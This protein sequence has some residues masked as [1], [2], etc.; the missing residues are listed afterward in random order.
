MTTTIDRVTTMMQ[1]L[2]LDQPSFAKIAG[3]TKSVVNQ[4]LTGK[5]KSI[6]PEYAYNIAKNTDFCPEW[7]ML[8]R[9]AQ[10]TGKKNQSNSPSTVTLKPKT[11]RDKLLEELNERAARLND[12]GLAILVGEAKAYADSYPLPS[13][14]TAKSSQ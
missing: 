9:G 6:A 2:K 12:I 1:E 8:G 5:I 10:Q 7:I 14:E 4:W 11:A 3:T 13:S